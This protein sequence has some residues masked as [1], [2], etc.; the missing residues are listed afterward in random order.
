LTEPG[1][2]AL[3]FPAT[4]F[5]KA[6]QS[7]IKVKNVT[8]DKDYQFIFRDENK[9]ELFDDGDAIFIV[10]GDSAGHK[11]TSFS[12][13]HVA[14]S[15]TLI[16]DT[17]IAESDQ[18]HPQ[19]GDV[20]KLVTK[21]PFRNGEYFE[22]KIQAPGFDQEK[23]VGDLD[24]V[25]VVPNPYVGAASWEPSTTTV[26]RGER[27]IFFINLPQRCS[28]RIYT[29][30][31]RHVKT[32]EHESNIRNGQES[33]NLVSKDGMDIAYGIY[34]YHIDAPDIGEKIDKFAV[35]K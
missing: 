29:I 24:K 8:E 12:D 17:T 31:G 34:V 11:A 14:W 13:L 3:S 9:N 26:G 22:F 7:N 15:V 35:I 10:M 6:I 19:Y 25:A 33:W 20:Y 1:Q 30:S 32:I 23:A 5:S 21:K 16:K 28:I 18:R 2:G 4:S 27:R